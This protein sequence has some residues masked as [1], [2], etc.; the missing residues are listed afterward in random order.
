MENGGLAQLLGYVPRARGRRPLLVLCWGARRRSVADRAWSMRT[1]AASF[2]HGLPD[3]LKSCGRRG[4]AALS[5]LC[6]AR[7]NSAASQRA[8]SGERLELDPSVPALRARQYGELWIRL[9][10]I[11]GRP[12]SDAAGKVIRMRAGLARYDNGG[13]NC[14]ALWEA[15]GPAFCVLSRLALSPPPDFVPRRGRRR[16]PLSPVLCPN[17]RS[18]HFLYRQKLAVAWVPEPGPGGAGIRPTRAVIARCKARC[19]TL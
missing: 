5:E 14:D 9:C 1:D 12:V 17:T 6:A 8:L 2:T 16:L 7:V 19:G 13:I 18:S 10:S 3:H 15:A 4:P 11:V